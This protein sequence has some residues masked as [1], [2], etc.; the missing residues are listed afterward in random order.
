MQRMEDKRVLAVTKAWVK[1][2][3]QKGVHQNEVL[4][5]GDEAQA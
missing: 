2:Q 5:H 3:Q 1:F 4:R